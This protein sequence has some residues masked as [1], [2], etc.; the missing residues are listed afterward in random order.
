[1]RKAESNVIFKIVNVNLGTKPIYFLCGNKINRKY[2]NSGPVAF[3]LS[4]DTY[5]YDSKKSFNV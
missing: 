2:F 1:M 3:E 5:F 4:G